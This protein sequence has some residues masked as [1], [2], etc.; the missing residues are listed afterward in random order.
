MVLDDARR[1]GAARD[2]AEEAKQ[3]AIAT[4]ASRRGTVLNMDFPFCRITRRGGIDSRGTRKSR[5]MMDCLEA[6][7][8]RT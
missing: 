4:I 1:D 2:D 7:R 5:Y 6:P 8:H 3:K